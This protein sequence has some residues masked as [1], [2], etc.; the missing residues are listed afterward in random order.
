MFTE[1]FDVIYFKTVTKAKKETVWITETLS[2][3]RQQLN[4]RLSQNQKLTSRKY[5]V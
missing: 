2:A 4:N 5:G 1:A 3:L